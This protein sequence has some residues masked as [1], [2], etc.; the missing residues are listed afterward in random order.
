MELSG[1]SKRYV[2]V[3]K[4]EDGLITERLMALSAR[5]IRF[6]YR[7]L[8][9]MLEREDIH[10]NHKRTYRLY[11]EAGLSLRNAARRKDTK[12]VEC[13]TEQYPHSTTAG[14]W[15]LSSIVPATAETYAY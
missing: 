15:I 2:P 7:R 14:R 6:G 10:I 13:R 8:K 12:S 9:V 5:W 11:R 1:S 3:E 4:T